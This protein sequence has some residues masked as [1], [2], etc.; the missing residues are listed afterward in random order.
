VGDPPAILLVFVNAAVPDE[1]KNVAKFGIRHTQLAK[2]E[3]LNARPVC[4][5]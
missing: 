5:D 2:L 3:R 1:A 4:E